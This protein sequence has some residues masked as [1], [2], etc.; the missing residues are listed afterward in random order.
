MRIVE[1]PT[2]EPNKKKTADNIILSLRVQDDNPEYNGRQ[3]RVWLS[4]PR[5]DGSDQTNQTASGM[6]FEDFKLSQTAKYQAA[7]EGLEDWTQLEGEDFNFSAGQEALF[8][9]SVE[10]YE[11]RATNVLTDR[12]LPQPVR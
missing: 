9:V 10:D 4:Q 6:S 11:G 12:T 3:F 7:F 2:A 5:Y 8:H 1:E